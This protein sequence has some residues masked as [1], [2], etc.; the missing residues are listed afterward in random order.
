MSAPS[1]DINSYQSYYERNSSF[2]LFF[3]IG[4][5]GPKSSNTDGKVL[6]FDPIF[7]WLFKRS[8]ISG[9]VGGPHSV[10]G[11]G[12]DTTERTEESLRC[13]AGL[14]SLETANYTQTLVVLSLVS[15]IS[16]S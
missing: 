2:L 9:C 1:F 7:A 11:S 3:K 15:V 12:S 4:D 8:F 13:S 14:P 16:W 5:F 10:L 6:S